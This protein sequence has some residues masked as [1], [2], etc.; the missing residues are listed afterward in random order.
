MNKRVKKKH[1][2]MKLLDQSLVLP[3]MTKPYMLKV[4]CPVYVY[5]PCK[6]MLQ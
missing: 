1:M 2:K 6:L 4:I 5:T 3:N